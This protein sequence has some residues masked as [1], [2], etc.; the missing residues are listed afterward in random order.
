[1]EEMNAQIDQ[2]LAAMNAATG[3]QAQI[4]AIKAVVNEMVSQ[5]KEMSK[6]MAGMKGK[7]GKM[8]GGMSDEEMDSGMTIM[9][10]MKSKG[11][12]KSMIVII[13]K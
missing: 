8:A 1:M 12:E 11:G 10:K 3:E 5:Q 2:K 7:M 4:E 6:M 13:Q 9:K